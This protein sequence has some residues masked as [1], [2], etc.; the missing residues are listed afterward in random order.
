MWPF[1]EDVVVEPVT[2][3]AFPGVAVWIGCIPI[4]SFLAFLTGCKDTV[5][6]DLEAVPT[7]KA[8]GCGGEVGG[9]AAHLL[10]MVGVFAG[11][12]AFMA[13]G[14]A[15]GYPP[16]LSGTI[17]LSSFVGTLI[18]MAFTKTGITGVPGFG[19]APPP[20]AAVFTL[21]CVAMNVNVMFEAMDGKVPTSY[22]FLLAAGVLI[23]QL[24]GYKIRKEGYAIKPVL[25][26]GAPPA[27]KAEVMKT[28]ARSSK[29]PKKQR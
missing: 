14:G 19:G 12:W 4:L 23:P 16:E 26:G 20:V 8:V 6:E 25:K 28:P 21:A 1:Y 3:L 10:F 24:A 22:W 7:L 9:F 29:S 15:L 27:T 2:S 5:R 13:I 17:S 11:G 18:F